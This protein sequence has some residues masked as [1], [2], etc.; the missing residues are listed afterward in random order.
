MKELNDYEITDLKGMVRVIQANKL[1]QSRNSIEL[2]KDEELVAIFSL[3]QLQ[4]IIR[5]EKQKLI[6]IN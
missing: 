1:V 2:S 3:R 5:K 4:S 6:L